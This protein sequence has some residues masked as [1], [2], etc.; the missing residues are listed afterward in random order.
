MSPAWLDK[1]V[2]HSPQSLSQLEHEVDFRGIGAG[3]KGAKAAV[4]DHRAVL[5]DAASEP[6]VMTPL[7]QLRGG[8]PCGEQWPPA[9]LQESAHSQSS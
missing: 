7:R 1:D 8:S 6:I 2:R 5:G 3:I 9:V 4:I